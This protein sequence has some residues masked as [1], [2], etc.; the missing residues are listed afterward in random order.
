MIHW[1]L[2]SQ[3]SAPT[4]TREL[5][6]ELV[7][8]LRVGRALVLING[9]GFCNGL[10]PVMKCRIGFWALRRCPSTLCRHNACSDGFCS[11]E[12]FHAGLLVIKIVLEGFRAVKAFSGVFCDG[13]YIL[14]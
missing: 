2:L 14:G 7:T 4:M 11:S 3:T 6:I 10:R 9:H 5:A 8:E 13:R 1:L 12:L